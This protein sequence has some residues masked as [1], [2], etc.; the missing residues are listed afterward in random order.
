MSMGFIAVGD[1]FIAIMASAKYKAAA[2]IMPYI[3]FGYAIYACQFILNAGL[4]I[5]KKTHIFMVVKILAVIVN[6][7]SNIFLIPRYG[8]IGAAQATLLSY[9]TYT[10][11]ITYFSFKELSFR[12]DYPRIILY[13]SVSIAM[14][15]ILRNVEFGAHLINFISK[16]GLGI[17]IYCSAILLIDRELSNKVVNFAKSYIK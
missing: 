10:A 1:D 17:F 8:I 3:V 7:V 16:I 5:Q 4:F 14:L 13:G 12:I 2:S 6:I 11:L 9:I 15:L